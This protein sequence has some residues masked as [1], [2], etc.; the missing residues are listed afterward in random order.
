MTTIASIRAGACCAAA[1]C[2]VTFAACRG[3]AP[4]DRVRVSGHVEATEVQVSP[5]VAG[6]LVELRVAE[7]DR[8]AAGDVVARIDTTKLELAVA[9]A[10]AERDQAAAELQLL[11]AGARREDVRQAEAQLAAAEA[12]AG[13]AAA[14][15]DAA[16]RDL[17]RFEALLRANAGSVKQRDDAATQLKMAEDRVRAA[18]A[19]VRATREALQRLNA[20]SR[21]EEIAAAG[22]RV[23]AADVQIA[24][25]ENDL[26]DAAVLAPIAGIVTDTLVDAGEIVA[27]PAPLLVIADLDRAWAEVFVDEP[28]VP[29]LRLGQAATVH[30]DAGG[31]G[32]AGTVR[33]ISPRAEFTPRNVQTA[34]DRSKL[35]YRVKIAVDNRAGT[36]KQGMPVE[37]DVPLQPA[38]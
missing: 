4:S 24:T 25:L 11:R 8:V 2:M 20:G 5:E 16:A 15:Q 6:R 21:R 17:E 22:A 30:T 35:V 7:G 31:E 26:Q 34:E 27:P 19:R 37:A 3:Q 9:R 29:R 12:E 1:A 10:R 33:Y 23:Q 38:R 36:L 28:L 32:L 18:A 13:A 14:E